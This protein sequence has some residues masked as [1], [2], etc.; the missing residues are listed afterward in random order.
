ML[1]DEVKSH[2]E[3]LLSSQCCKEMSFHNLEHTRDVVSNIETIGK[4]MGLSSAFLEPVII[5][6]WFHDTG[7]LKCYNEHEEFSVSLAH[8]FLVAKNWPAEKIEMVSSC[9]RSTHMPQTPCCL[10]AEILC[11]ADIFHLGT[12]KFITRNKLLRKEWE[13][14]L[15]EHYCEETWLQLN[16][17]F[18]RKQHFFTRYGKTILEQGK[19]QNIKFLQNKLEQITKSASTKINA[20]FTQNR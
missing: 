17:Q 7:F 6:G 19:N 4:S 20:D 2:C 9:I 3:F 10:E 1:I 8:Q 14:K 12:S 13:E 11:D 18:L 5:A 16:I 15:Q